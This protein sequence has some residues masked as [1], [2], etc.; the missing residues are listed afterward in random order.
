M[1]GPN[2]IL[3]DLGPVE[4]FARRAEH[5]VGHLFHHHD[6]VPLNPQA[7]AD[8]PVN[9]AAATAAVPREE[10][11]MSL[12]TLTDDLRNDLTDGLAWVTDW[13]ARV[14]A[15]APGIVSTVDTVANSTVGKLAET[16]AGSVLPPEVEPVL[17]NLVGDFVKRYGQPA[18][19]APA[20]PQQPAAPAPTA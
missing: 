6:A 20:A 12:T 2:P 14:K 7:P 13:A 19:V 4:G 9:L 8:R 1:T 11:P 16:L 3:E 17:V 10:A 5:A 15:A 18:A